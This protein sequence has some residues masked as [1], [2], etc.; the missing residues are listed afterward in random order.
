MGKYCPPKLS[1]P[2]LSEDEVY[3]EFNAPSAAVGVFARL[4]RKKGHELRH[5]NAVKAHYE[6]QQLPPS[7]DSGLLREAVAEVDEL[8]A[9]RGDRLSDDE[10]VQSPVRDRASRRASGD[11][12]RMSISSRAVIRISPFNVRKPA[13]RTNTASHVPLMNTIKD[14]EIIDDEDGDGG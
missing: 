3:V 6:K 12:K 10:K 1:A 8:I 11:E 5:Y 2:E 13:A 7:M 9:V 14:S 4:Q